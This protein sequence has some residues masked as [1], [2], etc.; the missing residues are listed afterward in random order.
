M[1]KE[2]ILRNCE[3]IKKWLFNVRRDFHKTPELSLKEYKTKEKILKYLDEI[4]IE[5]KEFSDHTGVMAYIINPMNKLT[6]GI[7]ADMDA[8]PIQEEANHSY[9]SIN[10]GVMHACGHDAHITML[11][12]AIKV[13]YEDRK[14]LNVNIKFLFQ[15]AE[16]TLGGARFL[17]RDKCLENPKV[18]YMFGLH[19]MPHLDVGYVETKYGALNANTDSLKI[20]IKGKKAHG[21]YPENGIDALLASSHIITALQSVISRNIS[22]FNSAVLTI[23]KIQ[24]GEAQNIICDTITMR[25]I[26]R[27][28]DKKTRDFLII[29]IRNLIEKISEAFGCSGELSIESDGFPA[30]INDKDMVDIVIENTSKILGKDKFIMKEHPSLGGEDFSFYTENCKGV[31]FHIG[32][33]NEDKNI[34]YP[35]HTPNFNID[36]NCLVIGTVMHIANV[37]YFNDKHNLYLKNI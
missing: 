4:G 23:G 26:L 28:L 17:V 32:C 13:L 37:Y 3:D 22:P 10:N 16:E 14:N 21:A 34:I 30:V 29:R 27:T 35:L 24:G 9:K 7:R 8:L 36:E 1:N 6:I 15:P 20:S 12:G 5:Y 19:V 18:D 11:L 2:N 31:F 33:R 25:G